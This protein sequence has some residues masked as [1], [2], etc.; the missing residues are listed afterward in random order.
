VSPEEEPAPA[1][2]DETPAPG[3]GAPAAAHLPGGRSSSAV[4]ARGA[5]LAGLCALVP[6][7]LLDDL[8]LQRAHR[9]LVASLLARGGHATPV[10]AVRPIYDDG[11]GC[12]V[13]ACLF[14]LWLP[15]KLGV[16]LLK[17][18]LKTVLFVL[19]IRD[20]GLQMGQALL[21]GVT[22]ERCLADGRLPPA[23]PDAADSAQARARCQRR[24]TWRG[25]YRIKN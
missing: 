3:D 16:A 4:L 2:G 19:A 8:L 21:L 23:A 25:P 12:L 22:V 17:K 11:R 6:V 9:H 20:A 13:G 7:P 24:G 14:V 10:D 5:L 15:V 18:L 1:P